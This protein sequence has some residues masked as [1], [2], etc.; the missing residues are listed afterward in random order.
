MKDDFKS[1]MIP[2]YILIMLSDVPLWLPILVYFKP[3]KVVYYP[4]FF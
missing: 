4:F 1:S 2:S 3:I